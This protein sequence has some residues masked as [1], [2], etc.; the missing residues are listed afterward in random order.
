MGSPANGDYDIGQLSEVCVINVY[1]EYYIDGFFVDVFIFDCFVIDRSVNDRNFGQFLQGS[2]CYYN[3]SQQLR[4]KP[5]CRSSS[6]HR[7][8]GWSGWASNVAL[9]VIE[10]L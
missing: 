3:K 1:S 8:L 5:K 9:D 10:G 6:H 4:L 7:H 2:S